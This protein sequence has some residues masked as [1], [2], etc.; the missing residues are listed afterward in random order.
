MRRPSHCACRILPPALLQR[1][2][3]NGNARQREAALDTLAVDHTLRLGRAT[4]QL[5]DAGTRHGLFGISGAG[6]QRSIY[7]AH[8][9]EALPG[10]LVRAEGA[11]AQGDVEV[12]E[13]YDGLGATFDFF[14]DVYDRNSI[15]DAGLHLDASVHYGRRYDNAFWNG[16]QMVF[17][18]GDGDLFNRFTISL[19]VIA[20][21]LTHGVTGDEARLVYL[22]QAGA[23]NES[24]SDVF[25]SLVKQYARRERAADADWLIGAGLFTAKVHGVA[26]RSM[27]APGTA[28]DDPVLGRD[29]QPATM[30]GY[31]HTQADDGG[32]HTN[33][34][35]PN[36][37]FYLAAVALGGYA[38]EKAGRIWY[39]TLR[40]KRMKPTATFRQFARLTAQ[41]AAHFF[42]SAERQAVAAAWAEVG[43]KATG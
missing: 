30:D 3:R 36:H 43:I 14:A 38:W 33:S 5:L 39:E 12:N 25:G 8:G 22:G 37:A 40:D 24:V 23:L 32:V 31:V 35:I 13:A 16:Q 10:R 21:E 7:D 6:K 11:P 28:Y 17:G 34:G 2:A 18:D 27:K 26:L 4:W 42:G 20:H 9:A 1:I 41:N 29:P 15:D 19:D